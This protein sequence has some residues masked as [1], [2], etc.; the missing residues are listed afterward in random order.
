MAARDV[1]F[2]D[3]ARSGA[4]AG[5]ALAARAAG[6]AMG[7]K[8][9]YVAVT[10][11]YG[12]PVL[13]DGVGVIRVIKLADR[14]Q[15]LGVELAR[16]VAVTCSDRVGD[17]TT[18]ATL[19]FH[20]LVA[21]GLKATTAGLDPGAFARGLRAATAV[22]LAHIDAIAVTEVDG[23]ATR[24]VATIAANGDEALGTIVA[25]AVEI[26]GDDGILNIRAGSAVETVM[27]QATGYS[28]ATKAVT[29]RLAVTRSAGVRELEDV[30]VLVVDG[31]IPAFDTITPLLEAIIADDQPLVIVAEDLGPLAIAG[32][33]ENKRGKVI[34]SAAVRSTLSGGRRSDV[35]EDLAAFTGASVLEGA[36]GLKL[37]TAGRAVL[38]TAARV[39]F[40]DKETLFIGGGGEPALIEGRARQ[41]AAS[42]VATDPG[43]DQDHFRARLA[44]LV[45]T[46]VTVEVGGATTLEAKE[47]RDRIDNAV[48]AVK[49]ALGGGTVAGGGVAFLAA[50]EAA[51]GTR[52]GEAAHDAGVAAL[53]RALAAPALRILGNGGLDGRALVARLA[54]R[55]PVGVDLRTGAETDLIAAG[56]LD[57]ALVAKAA[58]E[59]AASA[60]E[61]LIRTEAVILQ[62]PEF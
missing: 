2:G 9:R 47:K 46:S 18:A 41:L 34:D 4:L 19:I 10:R 16:S 62:R 15:Q 42:V 7:P 29:D 38:G 11:D 36:T 59:A 54:G 6:V 43:H 35:L 23:E 21:E 3:E 57:P 55:Y 53:C 26:A 27:T 20:R 12:N 1:R 37:D 17:G 44:H 13:R 14:H 32:L 51:A 30:L 8:G 61:T 60:A 49:A 52:S 58:L 31:R 33:V 56:I 25:E 28:L 50:A 40:S 5:L 39:V 45:G 22:A 24:H 48:R